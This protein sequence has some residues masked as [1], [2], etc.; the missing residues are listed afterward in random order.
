MVL[1]YTK[2]QVSHPLKIAGHYLLS[3]DFIGVLG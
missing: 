2:E 3:V 1:N